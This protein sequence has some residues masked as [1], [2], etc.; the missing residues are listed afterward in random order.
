MSGSSGDTHFD[1]IVVGGGIN[2]AGIAR[3][4][5]G[6]GLKVL[7]CEKDDLGAHTSSAST[8]LVH[9]GLRYLE[10]YH[11]NLV[12]KALKERE[13]LLAAAPH[14]MWPLSFVVPHDASLRPAWIMR[15]GLF[16]YDHLAR[17]RMLPA[18][19]TLNLKNHEAGAPL[20]A[21]GGVGFRY[22]DGW[23]D[24]ARL[25]VANAIAARELGASIRTRTQ[26]TRLVADTHGWRATLATQDGATESVCARIVVNA[27]GPW[28]AQFLKGAATLRSAHGLRLVKGS[29]IVVPKL[30]AHDH[31]Y[32][33]QAPDRRIVFAI[34]YEHDY[35]LIGT[36]DVD[37]DA[38][39]ERV[40]ICADEVEYLV[41]L[42]NRYFARQ[43]APDDVVWSYSGVRPLLEDES[44]DART[45]TRDYAFELLEAPAPLLTVF[46]GKITTFRA[47]AE[48]AMR[49]LAPLLGCDAS[50]WT[51]SQALPGG[52]IPN[53]DFVAFE[54]GLANRYAWLPAD[55]RHRYAR[56]Y[57][58]R[59]AQLLANASRTDDLGAAVAPGLHER[60]LEYLVEHEW[61]RTA[62]DVL[63][64]RSK[65]GLR[66]RP[67]DAARVQ[68][69]LARR[70]ASMA[71]NAA[72]APRLAAPA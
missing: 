58:T 10:L 47:L 62:E 31:A 61:A 32:V 67:D 55:L 4:A 28:A 24:D 38:S 64:R 8:K 13:V 18:S 72:A 5:A 29:H 69:W 19:Q 21:P 56:A 27:A 52:D 36:T 41:E 14:L 43:I 11:F 42:S 60:E 3:D 1:L 54:A 68:E 16:L 20:R 45:T 48:A 6:R 39:P 44:S 35:T 50:G 40:A 63:W 37:Y 49:R 66:A 15:C 23:V 2:G 34:P 51:A 70:I 57:G 53:S 26:C 59:I 17:R 25:V 30:F 65:L 12:R 22:W 9:G 7:L 71:T 33:L 46:G